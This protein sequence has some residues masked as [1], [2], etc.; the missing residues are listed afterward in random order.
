MD[1]QSKLKWVHEELLK[2]RNNPLIDK[3]LDFLTFIIGLLPDTFL[4]NRPA[5]I[6]N[7]LINDNKLKSDLEQLRVQISSTNSRL[8]EMESGIQKIETIWATAASN[9]SL[10]NA[11][12]KL[13][14]NFQKLIQE[15]GSEFNVQSTNWSTQEIINTL[16][17]AEKV[18]VSARNHG[19]NIIKN[20]NVESQK[21][22]LIAKDNSHNVIKD[23][24]FKGDKGNVGMHGTH[25]QKGDVTISD[26]SVSYR[27]PN[28]E[29]QMGQWVM[30]T[31]EAGNFRIG[32]RKELLPTECPKCHQ[33]FGVNRSDLIGK[34]RL[35]CPHCF[36]SSRIP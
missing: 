36:Q 13:F 7:K 11:L 34:T 6:A 2:E 1:I 31:D 9:T 29:T 25:T 24:T 28:S 18:I 22:N 35:N 20:V 4:V 3:S 26:A 17:S 14:G 23:S 12:E 19:T 8:D 33:K 10:Q 27:G 15:S 16:I 21:T 32:T 30:G 5:Q